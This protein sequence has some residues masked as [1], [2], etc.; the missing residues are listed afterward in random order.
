MKSYKRVIQSTLLNRTA[1]AD[2]F[3]IGST[4]RFSFVL[5]G[6]SGID[7]EEYELRGRTVIPLFDGVNRGLEED[8]IH[9]AIVHVTAPYDLPFNRFAREKHAADVWNR[10]VLTE[11]LAPWA[12]LPYFVAGFSGGTALA[13][14]GLQAEARCFGGAILGADAI[15]LDFSCPSHWRAKLQ[16]FAARNDRV[17]NDPA[18]RNILDELAR[19]DEIEEHL[20]N[21]GSHRLADY[22]TT[23]CLGWLVRFAGRI[24][25]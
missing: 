21:R 23:D 1:H 20:L 11:I 15:P 6:G 3:E 10:H 19:R 5:F 25:P 4:P 8:T 12:S 24:T 13:L 7:E 22:A 9:L 2:V 14:H 16:V 17:C 18:N